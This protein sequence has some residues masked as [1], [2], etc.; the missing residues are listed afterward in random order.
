MRAG[1][2]YGG[3][4]G[5]LLSVASSVAFAHG[6]L[7]MDQD[8][9]KL[10]VGRYLMH[11]AGYQEDAQRS[12]FCEDIPHKGKTVIVLDFVDAALRDLPVEVVIVRQTGG[13]VPH[14]QLPVVYRLPPKAYPRGT[15]TL[16]HD[17]AD[18]GDYVGLVYVGD[19]RQQQSVFPFAVGRNDWPKWIAGIVVLAGLLGAGG[20][21]VARRTMRRDVA[22]SRAAAADAGRAG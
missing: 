16:T 17:F 18:D 7:S 11:F 9:C 14:E 6:G 19:N 2:R 10:T 8:K 21:L 4:I 12:E 15:L 13:G 1:A 5:L 3:A 22:A 20:Y